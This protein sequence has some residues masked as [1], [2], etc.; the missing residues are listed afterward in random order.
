M[1]KI[2]ARLSLGLGTNPGAI[3]DGVDEAMAIVIG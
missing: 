2:R 3:E 1:K